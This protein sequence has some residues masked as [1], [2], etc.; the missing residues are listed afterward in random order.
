MRCLRVVSVL[1]AVAFAS[2]AFAQN[3]NQAITFGDSTVDS[4]FWKPWQAAGQTTDGSPPP[5]LLK[6]K[7]I[8]N[9]INPI[10]PPGIQGGTGAPVGAGYLMNSQILASYFGLTSIPQ[11]P[12]PPGTSIVGTNYAVSGA[13]DNV[14]GGLGNL[15]PNPL[16]PSTVQQI[17]NYLNANGGVA[18]PKAL[19]TV[20]SGGNDITNAKDLFPG[21]TTAQD[22]Y[23]Q[24]QVAALASEVAVLQGAGAK[25][26]VV[27]DDYGT[28]T[29]GGQS[30][31]LNFA[32]Q[33]LFSQLTADGVKY[34]PANTE[35][36][37][38][39]VQQ[40]PEQFGFT[41]ATV[42]PGVAGA[43]GS[44]STGSACVWRTPSSVPTLNSGWSQWCLNTTVASPVGPLDK[45]YAYLNPASANPQQTFL[46]AD[47]Q[48]LS[49]A[50]QKIEADYIFNLLTA[51]S[52]ISFLPESA[53]K[54]RLG[55]VSTIKNQI[56]LSESQRGPRGINA[57]VTGDVT[58]LSMDNYHGFPGDPNTVLSGSAGVDYAF[59]PGMIAGVALAGSSLTS[60]LGEGSFKQSETSVSLYAAYKSGP[61]W[62]NIIGTYGSLNYDVNR[63]TPVGIST[64]LNHGSASGENWSAALQGGYRF[65]TGGLEHGPVA[66]L[67]YQN[68]RVGGFAESGSA[69]TG[70]GFDSQSRE[71]S[72]G[73]FGYKAS[74]NWREYQPFVQ[75][76]WNH[77]FADTN[78]NVT[79]YLLPDPTG[80]ITPA[81]G[82]PAV[83]L[84]K[85][86]GEVKG[87]V[88]VNAGDGVKFF[89][90]GSADFAQSSATVYGGQLG[91][92]I[93]F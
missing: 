78:R 93:A 34:I 2:S 77:E 83:V 52:L 85:D 90:V 15:N 31:L 84:G 64:Q 71:S 80:L 42:N 53:V 40:N 86:W 9:S 74:Y 36:M 7:V 57:W 69:L 51:P 44:L 10:S 5:G 28:Q 21:N 8:A 13:I 16:L 91:I 60:A 72:V 58:A 38:I 18:N 6:N 65:W 88:R 19:Y 89:A 87:G 30:T 20:S 67:V 4:G 25:Y 92:N 43:P 22:L 26:I 41:S 75:L 76:S 73:Q 79:A 54:A 62:G 68:V 66:G 47:N 12:I 27:H 55:L 14:F 56:E 70:L 50:G 81:Y 46:F 24:G 1:S 35:W 17:Q 63:V 23:L 29:N 59:A 61:L 48:H 39:Y 11:I 45:T 32:N 49:A 37:R 82:L 3:Y 33:Q